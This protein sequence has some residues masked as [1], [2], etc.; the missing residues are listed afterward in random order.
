MQDKTVL[1]GY[2]KRCAIFHA[3]R[4]RSLTCCIKLVHGI[5]ASG[6]NDAAASDGIF[7]ERS[8][9]LLRACVVSP[10]ASLRR[11]TNQFMLAIFARHPAAAANARARA[12]PRTHTGAA[13]GRQNEASQHGA[14]G[15]LFARASRCAE[16]RARR[17]V[18]RAQP[19]RGRGL[20]RSARQ[21]VVQ[22]SV[23]RTPRTLLRRSTCYAYSRVSPSR[24][25]ASSCRIAERCAALRGS[26]RA[27]S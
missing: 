6:L 13:G 25:R 11:E 26:W 16:R 10:D 20:G 17:A 8:L 23:S 27:W 4:V 21:R 3:T 12:R 14:G 7:A 19:R 18:R 2:V 5:L 1:A 24:A 22:H 15:A 9:A